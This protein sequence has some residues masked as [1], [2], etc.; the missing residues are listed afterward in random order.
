MSQSRSCVVTQLGQAVTTGL[1]G[2][3]PSHEGL[4]ALSLAP[5]LVTNAKSFPSV[6]S[7]VDVVV[8]CALN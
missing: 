7:V 3:L 8:K 5:V 4:D 2:W 6:V 1:N